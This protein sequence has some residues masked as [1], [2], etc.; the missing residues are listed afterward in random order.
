MMRRWKIPSLGFFRVDGFSEREALCRL[1][2]A[3]T[4]QARHG[5]A[6]AAPCGDRRRPLAG[7]EAELNLPVANV[8]FFRQSTTIVDLSAMIR[9]C[10]TFQ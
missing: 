7:S 4:D 5:P 6:E 3:E 8:H 1:L 2:P 10:L 9:R